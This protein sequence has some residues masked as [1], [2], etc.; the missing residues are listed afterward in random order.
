MPDFLFG[1]PE[2]FLRHAFDELMRTDGSRRLPPS[3]ASA[4]Y[5]EC[6]FEYKTI[7][8][9]LAAQVGTLAS[10]LGYDYS[11]YRAPRPGR[12]PAY[13][14]RFCSGEGKRGERKEQKQKSEQ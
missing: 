6:F 10:L 12:V 1:L 2:E 9:M 8:P 14:V 11:V 13:R 4:A 7:S 5:R 3:V